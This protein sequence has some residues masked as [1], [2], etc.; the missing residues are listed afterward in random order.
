M[1][2]SFIIPHDQAQSNLVCYF[3]FLICSM[4]A[5]TPHFRI[6][7]YFMFFIP[8]AN[9]V[10]WGAYCFHIVHAYVCLSITFL[11]LAGVSNKNSFLTFFAVLVRGAQ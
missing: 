1:L 8:H 9:C 7:G 10:S 6:F 2:H 5:K 3:L 4:F 11:V